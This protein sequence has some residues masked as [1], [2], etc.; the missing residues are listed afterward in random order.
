MALKG[1]GSVSFPLSTRGYFPI[2]VD[3]AVLK[4]N[5]RTL[6]ETS[7]GERVMNPDYG[8]GPDQYLF[9]QN[10]PALASE[11]RERIINQIQDY[12]PR[13][14]VSSIEVRAPTRQEIPDFSELDSEQALFVKIAFSP[15]WD[16]SD[17]Q[18]LEAF[19]GSGAVNVQ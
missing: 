2:R 17:R 9:D 18:V 8:V 4:A 15:K 14:V 10:T 16:L 6:I 12:E 13:I 7:P 19:I 5:L 3:G 11:I 1:F